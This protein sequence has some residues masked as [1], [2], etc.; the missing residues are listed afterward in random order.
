MELEKAKEALEKAKE[1]LAR[2]EREFIAA[3][4]N[5]TKY[6]FDMEYEMNELK[7][8]EESCRIELFSYRSQ[9]KDMMRE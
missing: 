1:Q 9:L 3:K 7:L 5:L 6:E 8:Y 2:A 4:S